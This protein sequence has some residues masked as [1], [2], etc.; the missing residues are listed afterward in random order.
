MTILPGQTACLRCL[1]EKCPPPGSTPTCDTAGILAPVVSVIASLEAIEA[2]KVLSGNRQAVS[3]TL[4]VVELWDNCLRQVDVSALREQVQCPACKLGQF[5]WLD[6]REG[7]RTAVL[8]G[9]NAVQ[10]AHSGAAADLGD[11]ARRL[12][13][14][15]RVDRNPFLLRLRV[16]QFEITVFA[17][18]RAIVGGTDE[19][20][21]AKTVYS[22]YIGS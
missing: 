13:R 11:L 16:E 19:V 18:G 12:E 2:I 10:L 14:V 5:P 21:V 20:A 6:G 7:S 17:D 8:C 15:G 3:R 9:R 1:I 22:K 4:N